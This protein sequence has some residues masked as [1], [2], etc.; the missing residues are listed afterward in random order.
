MDRQTASRTNE[1]YTFSGR[2]DNSTS[3]LWFFLTNIYFLL[4]ILW[5]LLVVWLAES[6]DNGDVA[7]ATAF[8]VATRCEKHGDSSRS[9]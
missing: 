5:R 1:K 4:E 7:A 2:L 9:T 8:L 6:I 3:S